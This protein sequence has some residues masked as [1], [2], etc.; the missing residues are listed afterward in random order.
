MLS[1]RSTSSLAALVVL[2]TIG[3]TASA[4]ERATPA[5]IRAQRLKA[6]RHTRATVS[7]TLA[8]PGL[9]RSVYAQAR[10]TGRAV[11]TTL[12]HLAT[13]DARPVEI[14]GRDAGFLTSGHPRGPQVHAGR[15][16]VTVVATTGE[17]LRLEA[18]SRG[19]T[20]VESAAGSAR[21]RQRHYSRTTAEHRLSDGLVIP[22]GSLIHNSVTASRSPSGINNGRLSQSRHFAVIGGRRVYLTSAQQTELMLARIRDL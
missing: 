3:A 22:A 13:V 19:V 9:P 1:I 10:R 12:R 11:A 7:A 5:A 15:G 4:H 21:Q 8:T 16:R 2:A 17:M 18:S 6:I 20:T 14:D